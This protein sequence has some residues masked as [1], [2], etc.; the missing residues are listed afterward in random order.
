MYYEASCR[1]RASHPEE[2]LAAAIRE[3]ESRGGYVESRADATAVLRVP[4]DSFR[5]AFDAILELA[6][7][8]S[9]Q[10]TARDVTDQVTD[11]ELRLRTLQTARE[12]LQE[13]L[14]AA[15]DE[16]Q[17]LMLLRDINRLTEQI[18][19]IQLQ[20]R[21]LEG[22]AA[23][24]R[25]AVEVTGARPELVPATTDDVAALRWLRRLSPFQEGPLAEAQR[26][27]VRVPEGMVEIQGAEVFRAQAADGAFV[28]SSRRDNTPAGSRSFWVA[29]LETRLSAEFEQH[30]VV[31]LGAY[32]GVRFVHSS[33]ASY[34]YWVGFRV[35]GDRLEVVEVYSPDAASEARHRAAV[36]AALTED[37]AS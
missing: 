12:R 18:D 27:E 13:L 21:T 3:V 19:Q 30:E 14:V 15:Q 17:K 11:L 2:T 25:I 31:E 16:P 35:D 22:L 29:A 33:D 37:D 4:V 26:L 1:L 23:Y 24:S 9:R 36:V 34:R 7:V 5:A 32:A 20:L 8:L 28:R 6:V 10:M